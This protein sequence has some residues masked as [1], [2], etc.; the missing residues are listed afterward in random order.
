ML[1]AL[2]ATYVG[3]TLKVS[4]TIFFLPNSFKHSDPAPQI[5]LPSNKLDVQARDAIGK[6]SDMRRGTKST[7]EQIVRPIGNPVVTDESVKGRPF[8][9]S[10]SV[11]EGCKSDTIECPLVMSSIEKMTGEPRDVAW[12][13]KMEAAIQSAFDS[14]GYGRYVIRDVECRSSLC[15]LEVEVHVLGAA[16]RYDNAILAGLRPH[17]MTVG[18]REHDSAGV[19]YR[20][21]LMDFERR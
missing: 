6:T 15:V 7:T 16:P 5:V 19:S 21:Q 8:E 9:I 13:D 3:Y 11:K 14:Q 2:C 4:K 12:A 10:A 17:A 20:V 18:V 1:V